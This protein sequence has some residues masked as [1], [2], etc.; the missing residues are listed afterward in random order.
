[1]IELKH[2][3]GGYGKHTV[4]FDVSATFSSGEITS[5]VG[6]NGCG[7]STLLMMCAGLLSLRSGE[8]LLN[9]KDI[10][11]IPRNSLAKQL[12]YLGQ[13]QST[14]NITVESLVSHGRFPYLG[15]PRTYSD[16][17]REKI[18]NAMVLAGVADLSHK[19]L[20]ELSG[21]QQQRARIAMMLAQDTEVVLL[22]EPLTFLDI[23]HQLELMALILHLKTIGKT[24]IT[25]MHD[26]NLALT[27]SDKVAVMEKGRIIAFDRPDAIVHGDALTSSLGIRAF[28]SR[29]A[30]QY[31]FMPVKQNEQLSFDDITF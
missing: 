19:L 31:F 30:N 8:V 1:M 20:N 5:L 10:S 14:S 12:S 4:V 6:A 29:E 9:G 24:V 28:Y 13:S 3:R 25:V 11:K 2:I 27:Y 17:D 18:H 21:G 16:Q 26:L 7:K 23:R 15:Y 22:D